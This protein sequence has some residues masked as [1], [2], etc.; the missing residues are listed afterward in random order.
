MPINVLHGANPSAVLY[1]QY[2]AGQNAARRQA[3]IEAARAADARRR[4]REQNLFAERMAEINRANEIVDREDNQLAAVDIERRRDVRDLRGEQNKFLLEDRQDV[5]A[6]KRQAFDLELAE[7]KFAREQE[8]SVVNRQLDIKKQRD[9][10][11]YEFAQENKRYE[12]RRTPQQKEDERIYTEAVAEIRS[13]EDWSPE[14]KRDAILE[15]NK[16]I[17]RSR[18]PEAA[19][20][21][22]KEIYPSGHPAGDRW[23]D[24]GYVWHQPE[25]GP[26]E[27]IGEDK[28]VVTPDLIS[29]LYME[30]AKITKKISVTPPGS[31]YAEEHEVPLTAEEIKANVKGAL[32]LIKEIQNQGGAAPEQMGPPAPPKDTLLEG[33][34][35][36]EALLAKWKTG[37]TLTAAEMEQLRKYKA[38]LGK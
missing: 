34:P 37:A 11:D 25:G 14:Q 8:A 4:Q 9:Q 20:K 33:P 13:R 15:L 3:Q 12:L 21:E 32:E 2:G 16:K 31:K 18:K 38:S 17:A 19:L 23:S 24:M 30:N 28:S 27:K 36:T 22:P 10:T 1:A 5:R 29:R 6:G 35:A 7:D 26:A